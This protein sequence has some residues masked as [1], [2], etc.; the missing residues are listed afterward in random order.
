MATKTVTPEAVEQTIAE[1]LPQFGVDPSEISRDATFEQLDVDSLDLT[2][3]SQIL[4]EQYGV[5]LRGEDAKQIKT[6][7]D[8]V[9]LVVDRAG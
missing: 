9:D 6:V 2:E 4:E 8:V 3:M 7:G 1:A 5:Q